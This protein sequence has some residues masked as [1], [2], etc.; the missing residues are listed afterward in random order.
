M[1]KA[2][3]EL[4]TLPLSVQNA[5][6]KLS[7]EQKIFFIERYNLGRRSPSV[8][9]ILAI[10]WLHYIYLKRYGAFFIFI[11]TFGG[12]WIWWVYDIYRASDLA[13]KANGEMAIGILKD[14]KAL[15][16]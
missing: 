15:D 2:E 16:I 5:Y 9:Q 10:F 8:T 12:F 3:K 1:T 4:K 11:F 7:D 14:I 13:E 6:N